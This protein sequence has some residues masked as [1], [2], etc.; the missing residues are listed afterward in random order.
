MEAQEGR[1]EWPDVDA[2]TFGRFMQWVY[3]QDYDPPEP[4]KIAT[5]KPEASLPGLSTS[6]NSV[7][8]PVTRVQKY[9]WFCDR[10]SLPGREHECV[11][12]ICGTS[13]QARICMNGACS[14][15]AKWFRC[16]L[17]CRKSKCQECGSLDGARDAQ[18]T[19][20]C[21]G[22]GSA[23]PYPL[24][25]GCKEET[26]YPS[27]CTECSK[28]PACKASAAKKQQLITKFNSKIYPGPRNA[29]ANEFKVHKNQERSEDY[30]EVLLC[31]AKLYVLGDKYLIWGL[32]KLAIH[33]LHATLKEFVLYP[34][35]LQDINKLVKYVFENAH[36]E[37]EICKMLSLYCACNIKSLDDEVHGEM[38][39][40][41]NEAPNFG[42]SLIRALK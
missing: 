33:R 31:H 29:P 8:K 2:P 32:Q 1:V 24:C 14:N 4:A 7:I 16:C 25:R 20:T 22:C 37:D 42:L 6:T 41:V 5:T 15:S 34:S 17:D 27:F 38:E 28:D 12:Y 9:C 39:A 26:E 40:L 18:S 23:F 19:R 11:C 36:P 10:T 21:G 3:T 35:R 30:S 13:Y